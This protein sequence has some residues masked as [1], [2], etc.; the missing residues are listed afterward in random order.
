MTSRQP[1]RRG[2]R[3]RPLPTRE[4][5]QSADRAI[6]VDRQPANGWRSRSSPDLLNAASTPRSDSWWR[7]SGSPWRRQGLNGLRA[8]SRVTP[9]N[10]MVD[11]ELIF[12]GDAPEGHKVSSAGRQPRCRR[13]R[14]QS[15]GGAFPFKPPSS[16]S[17]RIAACG[18][19]RHTMACRS[20]TIIPTSAAAFP[21]SRWSAP[22]RP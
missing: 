22:C 13:W 18:H 17:P 9:A 7:R 12:A 1:M 10:G 3:S 20:S 4:A 6:E 5:Q 16:R 14:R 2:G 15:A 8:P 21:C 11:G 19:S